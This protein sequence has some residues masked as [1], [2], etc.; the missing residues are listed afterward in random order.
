M[1]WQSRCVHQIY[2][3]IKDIFVHTILYILGILYIS[4]HSYGMWKNNALCRMATHWS[5]VILTSYGYFT[6]N[7][8]ILIIGLIAF[9]CGYLIT[10][11]FCVYFLPEKYSIYS[12]R[13]HV[14]PHEVHSKA[15]DYIHGNDL[16]F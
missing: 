15:H 8:T 16:Y 1:G 10:L 7:I 6:Q 3:A 14:T 9:S 12:E 11:I 2:F 4:P 13:S 5:I